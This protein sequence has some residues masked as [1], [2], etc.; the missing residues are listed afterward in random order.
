MMV[1]IL[2]AAKAEAAGNEGGKEETIETKET[3]AGDGAG[4]VADH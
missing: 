4:G 1:V 2:K 3:T